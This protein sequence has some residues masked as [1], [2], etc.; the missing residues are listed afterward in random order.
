MSKWSDAESGYADSAHYGYTGGMSPAELAEKNA[1]NAADRDA[2]AFGAEGEEWASAQVK[3]REFYSLYASALTVRSI[4][5]SAFALELARQSAPEKQAEL[6]QASSGKVALYNARLAARDLVSLAVAE[7]IINLGM[8]ACEGRVA[9]VAAE[10][11]K[12]FFSSNPDIR[13]YKYL[14]DD[15]KVSIIKEA[16]A[17]MASVSHLKGDPE[18]VIWRAASGKISH[19]LDYLW[20]EVGL[21]DFADMS[22]GEVKKKLRAMGFFSKA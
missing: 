4:V 22:V 2:S 1:S 20:K 10:V 11:E 7:K 19:N 17:K 14:P 6:D 5:S 3:D 9:E 21:G 8:A 13:E 18:Y 12:E 15:R 16:I